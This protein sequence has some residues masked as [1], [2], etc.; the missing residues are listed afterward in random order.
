[1]RSLANQLIWFATGSA[2]SEGDLAVLLG[3]FY[4][5]WTGTINILEKGTYVFDL[6]LGFD[7]TSSIKI[8]GKAGW[9]DVAQGSWNHEGGAILPVSSFMF[10]PFLPLS[11][12]MLQTTEI[13]K[14]DT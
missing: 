6:D 10:V 1:M 9:E 14:K 4:G 2:Q 12:Q 11:P 8:D 5:K 7:T 13:L 3:Y